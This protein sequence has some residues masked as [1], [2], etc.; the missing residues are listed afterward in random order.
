[1]IACDLTE[2]TIAPLAAVSRLIAAAPLEGSFESLTVRRDWV[3][4]EAPASAVAWNAISAQSL[5]VKPDR[6]AA[7]L[8]GTH[9]DLNR[10]LAVCRRPGIGLQS[11]SVV[12]SSLPG[13]VADSATADSHRSLAASWPL[14][15]IVWPTGCVVLVEPRRVVA[16]RLPLKGVERD[17]LG[18]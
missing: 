15:Q 17:Q 9:V 1:V 2:G 13:E 5:M 18:R 14:R 3:I 4:L 7:E 16:Y 11:V 6:V 10:L 8:I 12:W